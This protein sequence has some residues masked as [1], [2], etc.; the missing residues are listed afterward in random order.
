MLWRT[1]RYPTL[2]ANKSILLHPVCGTC[3]GPCQPASHQHP[4]HR[5]GSV[6]K[7]G[8]RAMLGGEKAKKE[9]G[10]EKWTK[11]TNVLNWKDNGHRNGRRHHKCSE[12]SNNKQLNHKTVLMSGKKH[13]EEVN[14]GKLDRNIAR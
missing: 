3:A 10:K 8:E 4:Q 13:L 5:L 14:K 9:P 11:R 12:S 6:E 7:W 1:S 2:L